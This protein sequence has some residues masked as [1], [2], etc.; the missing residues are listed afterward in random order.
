MAVH[1]EWKRFIRLGICSLLLLYMRRITVFTLAH[2]AV[3]V[4]TTRLPILTLRHSLALPSGH[5]D[6]RRNSHSHCV[7]CKQCGCKNHTTDRSSS[8]TVEESEDPR[9]CT[10]TPIV[11]LPHRRHVH[12]RAL[13][14]QHT[15]CG[16]TSSPAQQLHQQHHV[17]ALGSMTFM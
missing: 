5:P 9:M 17:R 10:L 2:V 11:S 14:R 4:H 12:V 7:Q 16:I 8:S 6:A 1:S 13:Y 15:N 3:M